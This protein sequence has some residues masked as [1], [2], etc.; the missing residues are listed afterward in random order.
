MVKNLSILT[1]LV[2]LALAVTPWVFQWQINGRGH[3]AAVLGL[4]PNTPRSRMAKLG[5]RR[6]ARPAEPGR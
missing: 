4:D 6:P 2:G 1:V 5:I 3:A